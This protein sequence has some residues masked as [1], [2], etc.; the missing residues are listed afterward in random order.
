MR[1]EF[2][3]DITIYPEGYWLAEGRLDRVQELL[4]ELAPCWSARLRVSEPRGAE[5]GINLSLPGALAERI[6]AEA[7]ARSPFSC[8][9]ERRF[10][11]Q[12]TRR[13]VD[14]PELRGANPH[15]ILKLSVD[16][17]EL[18]P[19]GDVWIW[20]N[21]LTIMVRRPR[22]EGVDAVLWSCGPSACSKGCAQLFH[23]S[24]GTRS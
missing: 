19:V 15:L 23:P 11:S 3:L 5:A 7:S 22:V 24:S 4:R 16:E 1:A 13:V 10:G 18:A 20:G 9:V 2:R 17:E 14:F 12:E 8:E 6:L 21:H